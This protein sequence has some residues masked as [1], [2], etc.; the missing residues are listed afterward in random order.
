M[1]YRGIASAKN[2][3]KGMELKRF[4]GVKQKSFSDGGGTKL[5]SKPKTSILLVCELYKD[6]AQFSD[7]L[8]Q[9][10]IGQFFH[11]SVPLPVF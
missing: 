11:I 1:V 7:Y 5:E 8:V 9:M 2:S 4:R 6:W 3:I 10:L